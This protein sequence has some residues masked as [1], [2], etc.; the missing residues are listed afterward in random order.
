MRPYD[1]SK[2]WVAPVRAPD[3]ARRVHYQLAFRR[4]RL[5]FRGAV[6][7]AHGVWAVRE[8]LIV[9]LEDESGAVG[10]G[11]AA[12]IPGFGSETVEQDAAELDGWGGRVD[13]A[14][15]A[16]VP[17]NLGCLKNALAAAVPISAAGRIANLA[18]TSA[19]WPTTAPAYLPVAAL[20]PAG[21]PA[22]ARVGPQAEAGFRVFKW[23]VGVDDL[24][25]ELAL[26]D[27]LCAALPNGAKLRLDANGAW[28]RRRAERWFERCADRPVEYI[29]Q[30]CFAEASQG[31]A[32]R[33]KVEDV[34]LGLAGDYPTPLAL[35]ESLVHDGDI[36]R[37]IG[38]GWPGVYVVKPLLLG[39]IKGTIETLASAKAK[40]VFSSVL[41]TGVGAKHALRAVFAW[42]GEVAGP[43][44]AKM[45]TR[46]SGRADG[47]PSSPRLRRADREVAAPTIPAKPTGPAPVHTAL[48]FGVWPLFADERF[49]GPIAAPFLYREDVER[50]NPE[51]IWNALS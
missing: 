31:L 42:S 45:E 6:R 40:V 2:G 25:D 7:T 27:D 39:D 9:R 12:P 24:E 22:L 34:L 5:P 43:E 48:G 37:W 15:L 49:D 19:R 29:E 26:L 28:D 8:G 41:E 30:P 18:A 17:T 21:R 51:A 4:Y 11:E 32:G 35:D 36:E 47:D 16:M 33:G 1:L 46:P 50:I 10:Y 38:A 20:L 14:R 13:E 3:F 23:K 44:I